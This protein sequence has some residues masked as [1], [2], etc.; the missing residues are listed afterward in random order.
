MFKGALS[1]QGFRFY[2]L[3]NFFT[4]NGVWIERVTLGW[5]AWDMTGS[6]GWTGVVGFL[7]FGPSIVGAPFFG[8]MA[9]RVNLPRAMMAIQATQALWAGALLLLVVTDGLTIGS[10][11][12]LT[13]MIGI[14]ASA[15]QPAR[16]VLLP[17]L[18]AKEH[19]AQAVAIGAIN[20]HLCRTLGPA[21]GGVIIAAFSVEAALAVTVLGF[22]PVI[23]V[24]AFA[25]PR[26]RF[27]GAGPPERQRVLTAIAEGARHAAERRPVTQA[28]AI[29]LAAGLT[30]RSAMEVLPAIADGVFD[31]G[32]SG[33][34]QLTAA[35]GAGAVGATMLLALLRDA[36]TRLPVMTPAAALATCALTTALGAAP[37]WWASVAACAAVGFTTSLVGVGAQ[38]VVQLS[39]EDGFRG[40]VMSLWAVVG[41]GSAAVGAPMLG[42]LADWIGIATAFALLSATCAAGLGVVM[43]RSRA[44]AAR[45]E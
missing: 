27:G 19:I 23:V 45:R 21:I 32:A 39:V 33:L 24:L 36:K 10:L 22:I 20:F 37:G 14:T 25:R 44:A 38:T 9:D 34:G 18:V 40:R 13:L 4:L 16:M 15:Y 26:D 2:L 43:L 17:L 35:A 1:G 28:L 8:V 30:G 6:V 11:A 42:A 3:G 5:L 12:G 7:L 31:R 41:F 29:T